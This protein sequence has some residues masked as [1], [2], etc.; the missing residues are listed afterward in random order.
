MLC[1]IYLFLLSTLTNRTLPPRRSGEGWLLKIS[2]TVARRTVSSV[3]SLLSGLPEGI[4]L[5]GSST[6]GARSYTSTPSLSSAVAA[7]GSVDSLLSGLSEGIERPKATALG[8]GGELS[9][10]VPDGGSV[11]GS[12]SSDVNGHVTGSLAGISGSTVGVT[13]SLAGIS[14]S[15]VG[16]AGSLAGISGSTVGVARSLAGSSI[17]AGRGIAGGRDRR[18]ARGGVANRGGGIA[19]SGR[20]VTCR[21]SEESRSM[22]RGAIVAV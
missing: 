19:D 4:E 18:V 20:R 13:R 3:D 6:S 7:V 17:V 5:S 14:G 2:K 11:A 16:V 1:V 8:A 9:R 21:G 22:A 12:L 10:G 15:T